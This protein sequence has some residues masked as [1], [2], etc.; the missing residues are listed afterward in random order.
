MKAAPLI[1][2]LREQ[3][4]MWADRHPGAAGLITEAADALAAPAQGEAKPE[5]RA[6]DR[7]YFGLQFSE[8]KKRILAM[9]VDDARELAISLLIRVGALEDRGFSVATPEPQEGRKTT[10]PIPDWMVALP[11]AMV[12][13]RSS[14]RGAWLYIP[15]ADGQWVSAA[16]LDEFSLAIIDAW[17]KEHGITQDGERDHG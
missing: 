5:P 2:R 14:A 1:Q 8:A 16:K 13:D 17:R 9:P 7:L 11:C 15:H 12:K 4:G 3:A 6:R 10:N